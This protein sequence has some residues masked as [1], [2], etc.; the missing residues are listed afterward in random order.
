VICY[1]VLQTTERGVLESPNKI[2]TSA[3]TSDFISKVTRFVYDYLNFSIGAG[4]TIPKD[5]LRERKAPKLQHYSCDEHVPR[6]IPLQLSSAC[7]IMKNEFLAIEMLYA[8]TLTGPPPTLILI[9]F[10]C[11]SRSR[12]RIRQCNSLADLFLFEPGR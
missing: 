12:N 3:Y 6:Y 1:L 9:G 7:A 4:S 10:W 2:W 11:R 5:Q 8:P